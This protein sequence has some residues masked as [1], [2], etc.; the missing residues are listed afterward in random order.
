MTT[1]APPYLAINRAN[2]D[3]RA[4][5]HLRDEAG[6]YGVARFLAGEDLLH[7]IEDSEVGD[8]H[9]KRIAHLQCH[10]G[11]DTLCLARRGAS[12]VGLDFSPVAVAAARR[13]QQQTGLDASFVEGDVY[14]ARR[15][16]AGSFDLV[17]V[18]WGAINWLPDMPRWA[19]VVA[20]LLKPGGELY[21]LEGHPGLAT[22]NEDSPD[23]APGYDW[24]TPPDAPIIMHSEQT[25]TGDK[26]PI[27]HTTTHEWIH[28]LSDILNAVIG[29]GM[30]LDY[31]HEHETLA[32]QFAPIMV[33]RAG[34]RQMWVLPPGFPR[35]PLAF[36]LRA[37]KL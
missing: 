37:T 10:F 5:I 24:R 32:W 27:T 12:C 18:T 26:A 4:A 28:P 35:L 14:E 36:S 17:Y 29:A 11:I 21:L 31:L 8:V 25:Y 30:R 2:W 34:K 23:L 7:D 19:K 1:T 16:L 13:L 15:L 20:S 3:D 6:G 9:G 33:P 22:M